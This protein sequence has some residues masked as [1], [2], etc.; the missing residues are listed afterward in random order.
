MYSYV[1]YT[2]VGVPCLR[3]DAFNS[4][5]WTLHLP[6]GME[7]GASQNV[8]PEANLYFYDNV[9]FFLTNSSKQTLEYTAIDDT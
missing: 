5:E 3:V 6:T 8:T 2:C 4:P 9:S 1:N 7:V